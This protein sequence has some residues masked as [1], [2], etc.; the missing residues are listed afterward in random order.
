MHL[1]Q[2]RLHNSALAIIISALLLIESD[3]NLVYGKAL[4][5]ESDTPLTI[6]FNPPADQVL[7]NQPLIIRCE[8]H[9]LNNERVDSNKNILTGGYSMFFQ[10]PIAPWGKFCFHN[11]QSACVGEN[12]DKCPY[13]KELSLVKCRTAM[14]DQ[15]YLFYEYT[16]TNLTKSWLGLNNN[17]HEQI[18]GF[19]CKTAGLQTPRIPLVII[20]PPIDTLSKTLDLSKTKSIV[21]PSSSVKMNANKSLSNEQQD[22]SVQLKNGVNQSMKA[23]NSDIKAAL[24]RE[25]LIIGAI[26]VVF[27]SV[28]LNVFCCIRC[29]LIRQYSKSKD[30]AH[31]Q[32]LFCMAEEIRNAR[33]VKQINGKSRSFRDKLE[34][35]QTYQQQQQPPNHLMNLLH[36]N[37]NK[38]GINGSNNLLFMNKI[39]PQTNGYESYQPSIDYGSEYLAGLNAPGLVFNDNQSSSTTGLPAD[40]HLRYLPDGKSGNRQSIS[41]FSLLPNQ[42]PMPWTNGSHGNGAHNNN[43]AAAAAA[44]AAAANATIEAHR[45]SISSL[46][47]HTGNSFASQHSSQQQITAAVTNFYL[48]HQQHFRELQ[49][50]LN[51]T[52]DNVTVNQL[53]SDGM[54]S[55]FG[56]IGQPDSSILSEVVNNNQIT[57]NSMH[58]ESMLTGNLI[59]HSPVISIRNGNN[60]ILLKNTLTSSNSPLVHANNANQ[61]TY[62]IPMDST[63]NQ[64]TN[65]NF[66]TNNNNKSSPNIN[67]TQ[68][69]GSSQSQLVAF[70]NRLNYNNNNAQILTNLPINM[71]T[72]PGG[73]LNSQSDSGAGSGGSGKVSMDS[74]E[75]RMNTPKN[76]F[77]IYNLSEMIDKSTIN[78]KD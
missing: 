17:N 50:H 15:G 73:T 47:R 37:N 19:S 68:P 5:I 22:E 45:R 65:Q 4:D 67:R 78:K 60:N 71:S 3:K 74:S 11:C 13:E 59:N 62:M 6:S 36:E 58:C 24:T 9:S 16:I 41:A 54:A 12:P 53:G 14:T 70:M 49:N 34:L 56:S 8:V 64:I 75:N 21:T 51:S 61:S 48:Q 25:I 52:A 77:V 28:V 43:T 27:I 63:T 7:L 20:Q 30:R 35:E 29:A 40:V 26:I 55:C 57:S 76:D 2:L 38:A 66:P 18:D 72:P 33:I 31:M 1:P 44:A 10:C 32:H 69:I 46:Q 42:C 39:Q 23:I